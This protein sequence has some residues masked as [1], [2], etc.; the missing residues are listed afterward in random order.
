MS[1]VIV[2]GV[3]MLNEKGYEVGIVIGK[4]EI[5]NENVKSERL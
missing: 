1:F 5:R 2:G 3:M 4:G